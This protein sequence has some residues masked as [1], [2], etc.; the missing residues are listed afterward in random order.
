MNTQMLVGL[1]KKMIFVLVAIAVINTII[2]RV[3]VVG[4]IVGRVQ[5]GL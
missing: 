5:S 4:P 1:G 3:P 2:K